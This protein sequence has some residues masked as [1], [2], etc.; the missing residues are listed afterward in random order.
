MP[1]LKIALVY[2]SATGVTAAYAGAITKKMTD[3]DCRVDQIN[4]TSFDARQ[5]PLPVCEY[6]AF[7]FGFPVFSDFA[8]IVVNDWLNLLNGCGKKCATF[9]TYGG[10][11]TGYAHFHTG[12]IL[13]KANFK[14]EFSAE[15]LGPHSF[16]IGGWTALSERPNEEDLNIAGEFADL[17]V[18]RFSQPEPS[19]FKLQK[20]FGYNQILEI[21]QKP[22][23]KTE[24][25]WTNP[26]RVDGECDLCRI[27]E[28]ECP[29]A[30]F[31]V[32][33]G[34][35]DIE[36]CIGCMHCVYICPNHVI[37]I[38]A[39]M[40]DAYQNFLADWNLTEAI[41]SAKKSKIITQP[42]QANC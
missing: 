37:H 35:S 30:A 33:T 11:T 41:M 13:E 27:C 6:D 10:R 3:L 42:W 26:V 36:K 31:N 29:S 17:A 23:K 1:D 22:P 4:I 14:V 2:F 12:Q 15:F 38:D 21:R 9:F 25:G 18:E 19:G 40:K 7:I 34:L 8:P 39:R 32:D 16:N 24:R 20:P 28:E 5:K